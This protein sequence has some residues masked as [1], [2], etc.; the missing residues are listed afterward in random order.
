M[1]PQHPANPYSFAHEVQPDGSVTFECSRD[2]AVNAWLQLPPHHPVVLQTQSFWTAVGASSALQGWEATKWTALTWI[3]WELGDA[4][5][6]HAAR[7][8]YARDGDA[9][10]LGYSL[11][12]FNE[13]GA[14]VV[15]I[16]GRGVVFRT[17]NFEKWRESSKGEARKAAATDN[18]VFADARALGLTKNERVLVAPFKPGSGHV[19]ALVT[20]ENGLAPSNPLIGGSG[21]HVNSTHLHELGRQALFLI[22]GRTDID[23]SGEMTMKRYVELGTPLRLNIR[24][25]TE[26]GITF[27]VE[28]LGKTCAEISLRWKS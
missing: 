25:Q 11:D 27:E 18:F 2:P 14:L 20:P 12:L 1:A 13:N 8:V 3:D 26:G 15:A 22:T 7:G 9:E 5:G 23:T 28:Q 4:S 10:N 17:R 16:R 19:E 6:G 21:D 24:E